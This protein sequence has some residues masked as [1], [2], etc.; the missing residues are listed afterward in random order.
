[1]KALVMKNGKYQWV[2]VDLKRSTLRNDSFTDESGDQY[3]GVNVI[4]FKNDIRRKGDYFVCG[5]CRK[6][7]AVDKWNEHVAKEKAKAKCFQCGCLRRNT[8]VTEWS[9]SFKQNEDGS[10]TQNQSVTFV[11]TC[12]TRYSYSNYDLNE[13][14][15]R[16]NCMYYRCE[17]NK[18][19]SV[20]TVHVR[21]PKLNY[22][23]GI[24]F[25]VLLDAGWKTEPTYKSRYKH[26]SKNL[27]ACINDFGIVEKFVYD[28]KWGCP[29]FIYSSYYDKFFEIADNTYIDFDFAKY[30]TDNVVNSVET[31]IRKLY[32][33]ALN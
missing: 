5:A 30:T 10:V 18:S 16:G 28:G 31:I 32:K 25:R 1:M 19:S 27:Y 29:S 8:T 7:I 17:R 26:P 13:S 6:I 20:K 11:P 33:N 22:G 3:C 24:T 23:H 2:K 15:T 12:S 14:K 4:A 9:R 21:Y